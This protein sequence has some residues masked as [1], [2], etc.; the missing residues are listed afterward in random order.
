MKTRTG[1]FFLLLVILGTLWAPGVVC[2][3][4][5]FP[6]SVNL[7]IPTGPREPE[8]DGIF[9]AAEFL[10]MRQ[11]NPIEDQPLAFRGLLDADGTITGVP[12]TFV[13]SNNVA[14][15]ANQVGGPIS[16]QPGIALAAGWR[17]SDG[18]LLE[19]SWK[20]LSDTRYS[21]TASIIPEN[22]AV[23][24][25]LADTFLTS[26]VFNFP[27]EFAGAPQNSALGQPGATFGIWNASSLQTVNFIQRFDQGAVNFR[28][29]IDKTENWRMYG[30][31]GGRA[32]IMFERFSWR[33]V[34][35]DINGL[36]NDSTIATYTNVV[37][38]RM[39]GANFGVQGDW[40]WGSGP[41]GA[42]ACSC[43]LQGALTMNVVKERAKYLRDDRAIGANRAVNEYTFAPLVELDVSLWW[44]PYQGIQCRLGWDMMAIFNTVAAREPV[45]F[46]YGAITPEWD[47]GQFRFF[48]GFHVGFGVIF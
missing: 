9:F 17:F 3:Q 7:P 45:D 31:I 25:D 15:D 19:V 44:Y 10:F 23:R 47:A 41:L 46:N 8:G 38:Q 14:L 34:S 16:W 28:V 5:L 22:F 35:A 33:V 43:E 27:L 2:G 37:S 21:A 29:P 20:H 18:T 12:G 4:P 40:F 11:T 48:R 26:P 13:G 42:F 30:I 24:P 32:V 1:R 6:P 39:Y 36:S